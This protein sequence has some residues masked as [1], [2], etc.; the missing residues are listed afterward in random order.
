MEAWSICE[1]E[2]ARNHLQ[3]EFKEKKII[4]QIW[5]KL[6][7]HLDEPQVPPITL[8]SSVGNHGTWKP[9]LLFCKT[10]QQKT[11][12]NIRLVLETHDLVYDSCTQR[13]N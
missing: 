10:H 1:I 11:E 9:P 13:E 2:T 5:M 7:N 6:D 4:R 12:I 8:S 3:K